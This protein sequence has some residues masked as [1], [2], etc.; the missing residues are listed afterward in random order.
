[1]ADDLS[2]NDEI[3]TVIPCDY[4]RGE[5]EWV[6]FCDQAECSNYVPKKIFEQLAISYFDHKLETDT[7][8]HVVNEATKFYPPLCD[9]LIAWQH[10]A[11]FDTEEKVRTKI[12]KINESLNSFS[13]TFMLHY[14]VSLREK[15]LISGAIKEKIEREIRDTY[16]YNIFRGHFIEMCDNAV[17]AHINSSENV[18][19]NKEGTIKLAQRMKRQRIESEEDM[20]KKNKVIIIF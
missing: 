19:N 14:I 4:C 6:K 17:E 18:N 16:K 13:G 2:N 5:E 3:E 12:S 1:M 7:V 15:G 8:F 10:E 9:R 11:D 20:K